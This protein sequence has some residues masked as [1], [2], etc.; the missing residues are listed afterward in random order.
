MVDSFAQSA[1]PAPPAPVISSVSPTVLQPLA[2]PNSQTLRIF[3]SGFTSSST[4]VFRHGASVFSVPARLT[5]VSGNEV[6][7]EIIVAAAD[8]A[9]T[10]Q[11]VN[12]SQQSSQ[13]AFTVAAP[14]PP[15]TGSLTVTVQPAGAVSAGGQWQVGGGAYHN[16]GDTVAGLSPGSY[17]VSCKAVT[18]YTAPSSHSVTITGGAV[19]SDTETYS[20]VTPTSY[21]LTLSAVNGQITPSPS[22]WNGSAY[23]YAAGAVVQ[24]IAYAN[25]GYHFSGW[26]GAV[27]GSVNPTAI[28]M[29]GNKSV[30]AGFSPGDPNL[31]TISVT[32]QPGA[33]VTAGAQWKYNSS[34]WTTSGSSFD[35]SRCWGPTRITCSSRMCPDGLRPVL[36]TSLWAGVETT[37]L[38]VTYQQDMTP[39]L[40]TVTLSPPDAVTAGAK[41][42]VNGGTYGNGASTSLPPGNY[43]VTFD[44]VTGWTAPAS[45][46]VAMQPGLETVVLSGAY[47]QTGQPL[48]GSISPP[49]G[50]NSG[51]TLMAINGAN[52]TAPANVLIGGQTAASVAVSAHADYLPHTRE[53]D[54][55]FSSGCE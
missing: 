2:S 26:S 8:G 43:T 18:G 16:S 9:W 38:T 44:A 13:A 50:P 12:G 23:V 35:T 1:P 49:I 52:F 47:T 10:A 40:V 32:L 14:P 20:A 41:W 21:T 48:I 31:G 33:A 15:S 30:T 24:L 34:G 27:H 39:G 4:L 54:Q 5:F 55:R 46:S 45:Q 6:D 29:D 28:T 7:Y 53:F 37:N 42:H 25:S 19:T 51:G 11:V 3:G 22:G 36:S 17:T